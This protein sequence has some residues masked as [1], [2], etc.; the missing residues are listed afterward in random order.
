MKLRCTKKCD[1]FGPPCIILSGKK[2]K[3]WQYKIH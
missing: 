1:S 2:Y 3:I